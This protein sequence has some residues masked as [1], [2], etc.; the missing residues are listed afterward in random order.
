MQPPALAPEILIPVV[1][2]LVIAVALWTAAL[3]RRFPTPPR[4]K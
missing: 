4:R 1:G 2:V 3:Y